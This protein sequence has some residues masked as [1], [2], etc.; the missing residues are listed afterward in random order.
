V[1]SVRDIDEDDGHQ[2]VAVGLGALFLVRHV[3]RESPCESS[4]PGSC[5][6]HAA[7]ECLH[8]QQPAQKPVWQIDEPYRQARPEKAENGSV[9]GAARLAF[10]SY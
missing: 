7:G 4:C 9:S 5:P 1:D 8:K 2:K 10:F 6:K 3:M